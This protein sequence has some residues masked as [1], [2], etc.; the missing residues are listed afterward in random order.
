MKTVIKKKTINRYPDFKH[1]NFG[2]IPPPTSKRKRIIDNTDLASLRRLLGGI[3]WMS[4]PDIEIAF[5]DKRS[6][7]IYRKNQEPE[8]Y[9]R[10]WDNLRQQVITR[11]YNQWLKKMYLSKKENSFDQ[12]KDELLKSV[13]LIFKDTQKYWNIRHTIIVK[14]AEEF[15]KKIS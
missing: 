2:K 15:C 3:Y 7:K 1:F 10:Y 8:A 11:C 12:K 14:I 13:L 9:N 5:E 6:R 4:S